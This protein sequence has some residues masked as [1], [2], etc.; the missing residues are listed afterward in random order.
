MRKCKLPAW[1]LACCLAL[2][3][4]A[5]AQPPQTGN[6]PQSGIVYQGPNAWVEAF[7]V[8]VPCAAVLYAVCRSSR[9]N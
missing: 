7:F 3:T 5:A 4:A 9:R 2:A 8:L 1:I 6:A